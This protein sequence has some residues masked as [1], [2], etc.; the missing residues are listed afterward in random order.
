MVLREW[1]DRNDSTAAARKM[2]L[3]SLLDFFFLITFFVLFF[4]FFRFQ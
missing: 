4:Q 2:A 1:L 3:G